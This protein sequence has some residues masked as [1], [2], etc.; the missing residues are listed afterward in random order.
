MTS[1]LRLFLWLALPVAAC[2]APVAAKHVIVYHEPGRFGGWPANSGIWN[3]GDEILVGF[4]RA[5]YRETLDG[6]SLDRTLPGEP[7][8]ARSR[9]GGETWTVEPAP[10][11]DEGTPAPSPGGIK[12]NHPEFALRVRGAVF[13]HSYDRGR[14]WQGP[15]RLP[16]FGVGEITARTDYLVQGPDDCLLFLSSKD[17]RVMVDGDM[18]DRAFC[19]RTRDG[20]RTFEFVGWMS[21]EPYTV[22][23]VM[24]TTVRNRDGMLVTVLRRRFDLPT[25]YRNDIHWIDA[26][27][28]KDDG[29]NWS[30]LARLGYTAT[31]QFNGNPPSLAQT[32]DGVIAAAWGYRGEPFG[33]R[34]R[35]SR[36]GGITWGPELTLRDDGRKY[37][38]GYCRSVARADGR[39]VTVYYYTTR[40]RPETHIAATIWTPPAS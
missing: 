2:A 35:V 9:D 21:G 36:D 26:F 14:T 19:A 10:N 12:F 17:P 25:G 13:H 40:E 37:D 11:F 29:K 16:D 20:G 27:G 1:I 33:I 3:W 30:F 32:A 28:S 18:Q 8:F 34:G 31:L 5:W 4:S 6:H 7:R 15:Y 22:R 24:P 39:I 38:L 23:S